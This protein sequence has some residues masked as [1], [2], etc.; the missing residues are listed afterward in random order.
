[1]APPT[2]LNRRQVSKIIGLSVT[3]IW[4]MEKVGNFPARIHLSDKRVGWID[5]DVY[6]W[7]SVRKPVRASDDEIR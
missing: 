1:M 3:T 6:N 7:I 4:R 2:I 5:T